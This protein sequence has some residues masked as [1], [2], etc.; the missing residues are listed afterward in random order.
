LTFDDGYRDFY[1]DA[2]P[3]LKKYKIKSTLYMISGYIGRN[4]FLTQKQL[5]EI[6]ASGLVEIGSHTVSHIS[7]AKATPAQSRLQIFESKRALETQIGT[8]VAT[9]AYP[10]G[11]Y[12]SQSA[13]L[14]KEA[15]YSAAVS[16]RNGWQQAESDLFALYRVRAGALYGRSVAATLE[17]WWK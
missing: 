7:L 17:H 10:F 14:V 5:R 12:T 15:S 13:L 16:T 6:A 1:T 8:P 4:D 2:Y 9:F 11:A 3:L